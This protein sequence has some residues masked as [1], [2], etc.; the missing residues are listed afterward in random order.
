MPSVEASV[1][2]AER[3]RGEAAEGQGQIR[4]A[5]QVIART[6]AFVLSEAGSPVDSFEP[7]CDVIGLSS[8]TIIWLQC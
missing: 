8:E 5:L 1:P 7:R 6:L 2:R 3:W 4:Q